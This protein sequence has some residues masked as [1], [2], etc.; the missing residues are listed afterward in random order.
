MVA[1]TEPNEAAL[2]EVHGIEGPLVGRLVLASSPES[3][4][5]MGGPSSASASGPI[6]FTDVT[7]ESG[8][9]DLGAAVTALA[10]GDYDGD[11]ESNLLVAAPEP[12]LYAVHGGFV[13]DVSAKT[14]LPPSAGAGLASFV[15][16]DNDCRVHLLYIRTY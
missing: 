11:G 13:A 12:R 4:I 8:L 5:T 1:V 3:L 10:W 14:P 2:A 6:A 9:P 15:D 16:Y 7:G